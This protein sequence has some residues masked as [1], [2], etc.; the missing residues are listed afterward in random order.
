MHAGILDLF[1]ELG[2]GR[3]SG[4]SQCVRH[5]RSR[6]ASGRLTSRQD[7][8]PLLDT[9]LQHVPA[10]QG[11]PGGKLQFLV[12]NIDYDDYIGRI[13]IGRVERGALQRGLAAALCKVDGTTQNVR[14]TKLFTFQGLRRI[15]A[16]AVVFAI[17]RQ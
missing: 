14:I 12:S 7:I 6:T 13:A 2:G 16:E 3:T 9:I 17:S 11:E 4:P 1:I 10:P 8:G 5:P 15:E